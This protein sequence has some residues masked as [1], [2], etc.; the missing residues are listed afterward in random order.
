MQIGNVELWRKPIVPS[1]SCAFALVNMG[2]AVLVKVSIVMSDLGLNNISGYNVT[3][4]FD[5]TY[6]G[7]YKPSSVLS[8]SV[9]PTGVFFAQA[10]AIQ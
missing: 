7:I 5:G 9:N 3:E 10:I 1:G 2:T 6:M 8:V 4:V